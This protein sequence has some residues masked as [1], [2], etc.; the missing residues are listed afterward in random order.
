MHW[1]APLPPP[2]LTVAG[3]LLAGA[4]GVQLF[5]ALPPT[6]LSVLALLVG[7]WLYRLGDLRR[8]PGALLMAV[9][10]TSLVAGHQL[11]AR[12]PAS[13]DRSDLVVQGRVLGLPEREDDVLRFDFLV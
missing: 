7:A 2:G 12:L 4:G 8:L 5:P 1:R 11:A 3:A 10:W 9:A 13:A 6:A